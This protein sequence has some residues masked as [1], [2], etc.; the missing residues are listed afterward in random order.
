MKYIWGIYNIYRT[1]S[2]IPFPQKVIYSPPLPPDPRTS[3][4]FPPPALQ[5]AALSIYRGG[6]AAKCG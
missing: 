6:C 5:G 1:P 4:V 3:D 2:A